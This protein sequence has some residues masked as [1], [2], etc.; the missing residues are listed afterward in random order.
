MSNQ[1]TV[2]DVI[3]ITIDELRQISI[4]ADQLETIGFHLSRAYANLK[5]IQKVIK[6]TEEQQEEPEISIEP[7]EGGKEDAE[8]TQLE[9]SV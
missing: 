5:L 6:D 8:E 7:I 3:N 9:G 4:P 2:K 1:I